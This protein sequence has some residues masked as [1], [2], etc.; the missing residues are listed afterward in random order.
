MLSVVCGVYL[1]RCLANGC[2][3]V[4]QAK[5][6]RV[7]FNHHKHHLRKNKHGNP[8]LQH[9]WNAH[10]ED[11]FEFVIIE[12]CD[13]CEL[14]EREQYNLDVI[15][16]SGGSVFN[17]GAVAPCPNR[18]RKLKPLP[19]EHKEKIRNS[20]LGH[21]RSDEER[22]LIAERSRG[23]VASEETREKQRA[24]KVGKKQKPEH[25]AKA[26]AARVGK[27]RKVNE[28]TRQRLVERNKAMVF[29]PEIRAKMRK[30]MLGRTHNAAT[31]AKCSEAAKAYWAKIKLEVAV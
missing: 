16:S 31:K 29:T 13:V 19:P 20:L 11:A 4:G 28:D 1:I 10:G 6:C 8:R 3:Y 30:A 7:R 25:A 15:K 27:P 9:A 23:R 21:K 22:K 17:C 18:G 12:A 14:D 2:V 5:N 24:A 26:A